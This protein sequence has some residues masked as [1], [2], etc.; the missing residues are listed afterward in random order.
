M[1]AVANRLVD[2]KLGLIRLLTPSFD[3]APMNP[4]YI[5]GYVPGV[6]ENGGQ[7]THAAI[8]TAMAFCTLRDEAR[9]ASLLHMLNPIH[10]ADSPAAAARYKVEPYVMAADIYT[11]PGQLGRGG[12]TWYTG[13]SG[14]MYRLILESVLGMRL[15][16][17][18]LSFLPCLPSDWNTFTLSYRHGRSTYTV[19]A[20]RGDG[21]GD[22][23]ARV[24]LDGVIQED[25][26]ITLED[27]GQHRQVH[28][29]LPRVQTRLLAEHG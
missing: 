27:D 9:V 23:A 24:T 10:H 14:L 7:Y 4:G 22:G 11:T 5:R 3:T 16:A 12:W 6:R 28:I 13:S 8:W 21:E 1:Q 2:D 25:G 29:E 17:G 18:T 15:R 26:I 19:T 20:Q